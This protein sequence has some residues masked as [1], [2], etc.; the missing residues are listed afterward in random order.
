MA[1]GRK[2]R[3][4]SFY[5]AVGSLLLF[6]LPGF[7]DRNHKGAYMLIGRV[8]LAEYL[9]VNCSYALFTSAHT[10]AKTK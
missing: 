4:I 9:H 3:D 8:G 7:I 6:A 2:G 1:N 5:K 10:S